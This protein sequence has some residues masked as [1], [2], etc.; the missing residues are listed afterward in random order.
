MAYIKTNWVAGVTPLSEANLDHL[1]TQYDEADTQWNI[2]IDADIATHAA[3]P[4]VHHVG[5]E[6][7]G[8]TVLGGPAASIEFSGIASGYA[9]FLLFWHDLYG[10]NAG[11]QRMQLTFNSDGGTNYDWSF[12]GFNSA[13]D[14]QHAENFIDIGNIGD[15][16]STETHGNGHLY[17]LNRASQEKISFGHT[18]QIKKAGAGAEDSS[19]FHVEGKW[20]NV[21]AE[22]STI[23]LTVSV[24]NF[25][26]GSRLILLGV[27]T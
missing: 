20:R 5:F 25:V 27:K 6:E 17:I 19:G 7:I 12:K 22:I 24:G 14:T 11:N 3:L 9:T 18:V 21:A 10:D 23:T 8:D 15:T 13:S 4:R 16:A 1:E 2:D 26:A